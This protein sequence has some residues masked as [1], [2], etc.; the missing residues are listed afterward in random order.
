MNPLEQIIIDRIKQKGPIPFDQFMEMALYYPDLGYY[1]SPARTIGKK[2][3]FYTSPHLHPI[4]GAMIAKQLM[5]M[6]EI[7]GRPPVFHTVEI[8]AGL[9]YLCKDIFDFLCKSPEGPS[10]VQDKNDFL[11]SLSYVIIEPYRHFK[12][13]QAEILGEHSKSIQWKASLNECEEGMSGCIL[14]NELLDAF[15]VHL[16]EMRNELGELYVNHDGT[17]F[18]EEHMPVQSSDISKYVEQFSISLMAG[19]R[20]EINMKIKSW[21]AM[22]SAVL[23]HGFVLTI[24]YGHSAKE[25]YDEDRTKGTLLCYHQHMFNENPYTYIGEQDITAHV[26][27]SSVMRWGEEQGLRTAGYCPQGTYMISSGID[28]VITELY[29]DAPDYLSEVSKIKGLI[30]PGGMGES[31]SVMIQYKGEGMPE[32]RGFSMRNNRERL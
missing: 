32:L 24:D 14:S 10:P 6:W 2:G 28:E 12:V 16:I 18:T 21:L 5:E 23:Q 27:F 4:F 8:G 26:N 20:T 9:G 17:A 11:E 7:M 3:D 25:Y 30:M 22:I 29:A 31:H 1:S 15:P 13:S 19:Y